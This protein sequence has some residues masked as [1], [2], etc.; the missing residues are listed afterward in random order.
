M[1]A[2]NHKQKAFSMILFSLCI[3]GMRKRKEIKLVE[4]FMIKF[5][6]ICF[7]KKFFCF[8]LQASVKAIS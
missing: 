3:P 1:L 7:Q 2:E 5:T 6:A 8:I 4:C